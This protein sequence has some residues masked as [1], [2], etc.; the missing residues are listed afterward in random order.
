MAAYQ[1]SSTAQLRGESTTTEPEVTRTPELGN[2]DRPPAH[3][4]SSKLAGAPD[5][6]E[7]GRALYLGTRR[8]QVTSAIF[9]LLLVVSWLAVVLTHATGKHSGDV[10][11]RPP[12]SHMSDY[13]LPP[14]GADRLFSA[15]AN[16]TKGNA[17]LD[18]RFNKMPYTTP[19]EYICPSRQPA[20]SRFDV[21]ESSSELKKNLWCGYNG[22]DS[23]FRP[24]H[25]PLHL[26]SAVVL[27]CLPLTAPAG[28]PSAPNLRFADFLKIQDTNRTTRPSLLVALGGP[29]QDA[30]VLRSLAQ[31][32]HGNASKRLAV[33]VLHFVEFNRL[34]GVLLYTLHC[35]PDEVA[36]YR[37]LYER[38]DY[39]GYTAAVTCP[40]G[41]GGPR[42]FAEAKLGPVVLIPA[43]ANSSRTQCPRGLARRVLDDGDSAADVMLGVRL[44]GVRYTFPEGGEAI[45]REGAAAS[46]VSS[47][48]YRDVCLAIRDH[49]WSGYG[50][51]TGE[52]VVAHR[53]R[54]WMAA[55]TPWALGVRRVVGRFAKTGVVVLDV[56]A[57]DASSACGAR[58]FPL[59][60]ALHRLL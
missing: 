44:S 13:P 4:S 33:H 14:D 31:R 16:E 45:G 38:L 54:T 36:I 42:M 35:G 57:D 56:D 10:A 40:D 48:A 27:C 32:D 55:L 6:L 26:C 3:G 34:D 20:R 29:Q 5:V 22:S 58:S 2:K 49:G 25:L 37:A 39:H 28:E 15:A 60:D 9:F 24:H 47:A 53:N 8:Q 17:R 51:P 23:R 50:S 12:P 11:V 43:S 30:G 21:Q 46:L 41:E 7:D 18:I 1:P 59:T 52:C 19:R